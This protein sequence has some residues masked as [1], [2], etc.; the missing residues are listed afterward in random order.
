MINKEKIEFI[1]KGTTLIT[2]LRDVVLPILRKS[3]L[4][5]DEDLFIILTLVSELYGMQ[6]KE[7]LELFLEH[8]SVLKHASEMWQSLK[9][10]SLCKKEIKVNPSSMN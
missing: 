3:T 4:E 9:E 10:G 1:E 2:K 6:K 8:V 7:G 5:V